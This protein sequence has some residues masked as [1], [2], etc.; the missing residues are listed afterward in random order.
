MCKSISWVKRKIRKDKKTAYE[1]TRK[2][3]VE[4]Y[5]IASICKKVPEFHLFSHQTLKNFASFK[6]QISLNHTSNVLTV[7]F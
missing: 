2:L 5:K 6:L 7:K 4:I 1:E 3:L